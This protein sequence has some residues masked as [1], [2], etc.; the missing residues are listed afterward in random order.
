[1]PLILAINTASAACTIAVLNDGELREFR[2]QG[3]R[4]AAARILPLINEALQAEQIR[5][6][7][8]DAVVVVT[9]PGSFTGMRIGVAVAQG[10]SLSAQLPVVPVSSLAL[11]ARQVALTATEPAGDWLIGQAAREEELYLGAFQIGSDGL[12]KQLSQEWVGEP[13]QLAANLKAL[14]RHS[15]SL[16]GEVFT[17]RDGLI[18]SLGVQAARVVPVPDESMRAL[19]LLGVEGLAVDNVVHGEQLLPNYV[20]E[21]MNYRSA[22]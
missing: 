8:L 17:E 7:D 11:I 3:K 18:A 4:Q 1:M 2:A 10:L 20:K 16:A 19:C 21:Q 15:W 13:G 14:Q 12:L 6:T 9:G 5:L 22:S